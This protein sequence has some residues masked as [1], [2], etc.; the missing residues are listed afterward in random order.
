MAEDT[1]KLTTT[2]IKNSF[3]Y[4]LTP[5]KLE[6]FQVQKTF[7]EVKFKN[8]TTGFFTQVLSRTLEKEETKQIGSYHFRKVSIEEL[9]SLRAGKK[10]GFVLKEYRDY[11]Y[12]EIP[13]NLRFFS[14]NIIGKHMCGEECVH[15]SAL[16]DSAGGCAKV[17][18]HSRFIEKFDFIT[19]GYE[20]FNTEADCFVVIACSNYEHCKRRK[21]RS[22]LEIQNDKLALG[23]F[24]SDSVVTYADVLKLKSKIVY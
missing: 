18:N 23:Q 13:E 21:Q 15:L 4:V 14:E 10:P 16:P 9:T 20:S 24:Y 3:Y 6:Y 1:V 8:K 5:E 12:T 11:Y 22:A 2:Q 17:R 7:K 19:K